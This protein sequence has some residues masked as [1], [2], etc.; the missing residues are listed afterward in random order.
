MLPLATVFRCICWNLHGLARAGCHLPIHRV[1]SLGWHAI[2]WPF[3]RTFVFSILQSKDTDKEKQPR[4]CSR[5][6]KITAEIKGISGNKR[7]CKMVVFS[8]CTILLVAM[9]A[10]GMAKQNKLEDWLQAQHK[11]SHWYEK[12]KRKVANA[13]RSYLQ[14]E[15]S[16]RVSI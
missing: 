4:H 8:R 6:A 2:S 11:K 14:I 1:M 12:L 16:K 13:I 7:G 9:H 5:S 10:N 3:H 15:W